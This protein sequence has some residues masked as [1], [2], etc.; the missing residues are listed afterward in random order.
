MLPF[1]LYLITFN[2]GRTIIDTRAFSHSLLKAYNG[3]NGLPD[4]ISISLQ[5]IAPIAHSFLGGSLLKP[6]YDPIVEAV[7]LAADS[8]AAY[9]E[10]KRHNAG[11]TAIIVLAKSTLI[12]QVQ[13]VQTADIGVG[14]YDL[15]NKGAAGVRVYLR[16]NNDD[17]DPVPLTFVSAHLAPHEMA[18]ERRNRDWTKIVTGLA[19]SSSAQSVDSL[20]QSGDVNSKNTVESEPLLSDE[21]SQNSIGSPNT[22]SIFNNYPL[23]F[24]GDLNYRASDVSP[25]V[26]DHQQYPQPVTDPANAKHYSR[27]LKR[28]QLS[29]ERSAGRTMQCLDELPVEFPPTY[30]YDVDRYSDFTSEEPETWYWAKHRQ[31]S[32]CDRILFSSY[33]SSGAAKVSS[34]SCMP[35]QPTSDHRPVG[36]AVQ[37]DLEHAK[38]QSQSYKSPLP[39]DTQ[40]QAQRRV[41]K[42]RE[43]VV[44]M[45]AYLG[46]TREGRTISIAAAIGVVGVWLIS[47]SLGAS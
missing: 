40:W 45:G 46:L 4:I 43:F 13:L 34:Y 5:E 47:R 7:N 15:G 38:S 11:M 39:L 8:R 35:I 1:D 36:L 25:K 9:V 44:G 6:Y 12:N 17:G 28:D 14:D 41:A 24:S 21:G 2:C 23:F 31:P 26:D 42:K 29:R 37:L 32:W 22:P 18:V 10:L 30:K 33:L 20:A 3:Q 16:P 27:L 19:F